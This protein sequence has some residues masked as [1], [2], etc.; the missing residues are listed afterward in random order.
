M[1]NPR[2]SKKLE[3][4]VKEKLAAED[5]HIIAEAAAAAAGDIPSDSPSLAA[6]PEDGDSTGPLPGEEAGVADEPSF[7]SKGVV[8]QE[9]KGRG[10]TGV[11]KSD[12]GVL[13]EP[14]VASVEELFKSDAFSK[15]TGAG[16]GGE[17]EGMGSK[18]DDVERSEGGADSKGKLRA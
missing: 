8:A 17:K 12:G 5:S 15:R 11:A 14:G 10:G 2:L 13:L 16:T 9:G 6:S 1:A 4:A 18:P 3:A 7:S